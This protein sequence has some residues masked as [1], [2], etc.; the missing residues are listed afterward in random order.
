MKQKINFDAL[1]KRKGNLVYLEVESPKGKKDIV[2]AKLLKAFVFL[3]KRLREFNILGGGWDWDEEKKAFFWYLVEKKKID[4]FELRWGPP[5]GLKKRVNDFK[6][7][8]KKT[9]E[10]KGRICAKVPRKFYDLKGYVKNEVKSDYF[11]ERIKKIENIK[12]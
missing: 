7:V 8:H 11:K 5:V 12:F 3:K 6:K 4:R 9:F 10:E 1:K 2:G